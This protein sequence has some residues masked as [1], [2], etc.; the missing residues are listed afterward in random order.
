MRDRSAFSADLGWAV[1]CGLDW[2][3]VGLPTLFCL[4][5]PK[6]LTWAGLCIGFGVGGMFSAG[7]DGKG[8]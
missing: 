8:G 5:G 6:G 4:L 3:G 1:A 2:K 7:W